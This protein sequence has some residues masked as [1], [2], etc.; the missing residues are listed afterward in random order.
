LREQLRNRF[1]LSRWI[2][3]FAVVS[4]F[5]LGPAYRPEMQIDI[6]FRFL[7]AERTGPDGRLNISFVKWTPGGFRADRTRVG[8][9]SA[10]GHIGHQQPH[11]QCVSQTHLLLDLTLSLN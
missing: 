1:V 8:A 9:A 7:A 5:R 4:T 11:P 2:P 10:S 3:G 6:G